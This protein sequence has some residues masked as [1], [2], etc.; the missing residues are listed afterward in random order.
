MSESKTPEKVVDDVVVSMEYS[1]TVD[2]E[3]IDSSEEEGPIEFLQ[4]HG[5]I[6]PGLESALAGMAVGE[7]KQVSVE[8]A[9]GYGEHDPEAVDEVALADF[10]EEIPVKEGIELQMKDEDGEE[11]FARIVEVSEETATLDFNHP[12]AGKELHFDVKI[13][14]LRA[15]TEEEVAHGH[16]HMEGHHH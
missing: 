7:S 10:P 4:G 5:N 6:I 9:E 14:G 1:L 3:V 13:V 12:L 8:A 15:A 2:G 16:V 11:M